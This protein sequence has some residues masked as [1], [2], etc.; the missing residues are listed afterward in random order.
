MAM[1]T[2]YVNK[3]VNRMLLEVHFGCYSLYGIDSRSGVF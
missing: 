2:V 3:N 1:N